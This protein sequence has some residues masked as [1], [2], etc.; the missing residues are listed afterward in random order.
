ML[1][2]FDFIISS[3]LIICLFSGFFKGAIRFTL[4]N[5]SFIFSIFLSFIL[6][7]PAQNVVEEYVQDSLIVNSISGSVAYIISL[8]LSSLFFSK[9]KVIVKPICGGMIDKTIGSLMGLINGVIIA[10]VLFVVVVFA[11]SEK[12]VYDHENLYSI[13]NSIDQDSSSNT[14]PK[15]LKN[16]KSFGLIESV[17]G[18]ILKFSYIADFL[19]SINWNLNEPSDKKSHTQNSEPLDKQLDALLD[20]ESFN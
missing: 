12:H 11:A 14:Y 8:I 20:D 15:W 4:G 16:S 9:I 2:L 7:A 13:I 19:K 10:L 5:I 3:I 1:N 18:S 6:F 17:I